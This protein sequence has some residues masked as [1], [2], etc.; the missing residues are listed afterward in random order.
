MEEDDEKLKEVIGESRARLEDTIL[1]R[2][3]HYFIKK[4]Y[5]SSLR[6]WS[7]LDKLRNKPNELRY[8]DVDGA[9][10][11]LYHL[12]R[13]EESLTYADK[14]V[15]IVPND[16]TAWNL[17]ALVLLE[18]NR[19]PD[20]LTSFLTSILCPVPV[21]RSYIDAAEIYKSLE[22]VQAV[23]FLLRRFSRSAKRSKLPGV[24]SPLESRFE[25]LRVWSESYALSSTNSDAEG[26]DHSFPENTALVELEGRVFGSGFSALASRFTE[27]IDDV[28]PESSEVRDPS[29]M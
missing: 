20:A 8:E 17:R 10:R 4:D 27:E 21:Y 14:L 23:K 9:C 28:E 25:A 11:C 5:E 1:T 18:L 3:A 26:R 22:L 16:A 15:R 24:A 29:R 6:C 13:F 12:K 19:I 2:A 7:K